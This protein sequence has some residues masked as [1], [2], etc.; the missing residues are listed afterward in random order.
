MKLKLY[1]IDTFADRVFR[2]NPA[3][4]IPLDDWLDDSIMQAIAA[5]NNLSETAFFVP[6]ENGY[7]LRWFSPVQEVPFCGHATL[8]SAFVIF[9]ILGAPDQSIRFE[10]LSGELAVTKDGD[11]FVMDFP[12]MELIPC[13]APAYLL[14]G[15]G[16]KPTEIFRVDADPNYYAVYPSEEDVRSISPDL[17]ALEQLH[18]YGV[19]IT[20]PGKTADIISRYFAPSYGIPED[21][22]TGSIH[23]ALVPY[24][25]ER[26][27]KPKLHAWQVSQRGGE[28]FCEDRQDRVLVAGRGVKFLEGEIN[29]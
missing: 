13:E 8:A 23:A 20:A 2:G 15:L 3:A 26:L 27:G 4:V 7:H 22:V 5:E 29:L 14:D 12:R 28:L 9:H 17:R 24:W 25:S 11:L 6:K 10:T 18:P 16:N 1:Q 21:P 19:V